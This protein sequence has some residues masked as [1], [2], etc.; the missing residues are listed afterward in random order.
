MPCDRRDFLKQ[1]GTLPAALMAVGY[2]SAAAAPAAEPKLPQIRLGR[3]SI[4]RLICGA[5]PFNAGSHLSVFV[6]H[7]MNAYYTPEQI[8]KTLRR[9]QEVGINCWQSGTGNLGLYRR[10]LDQGG[11]LHFIAIDSGGPESIE[12]LRR[13][14]CI[15]IAHHGETTDQLFKSGRI[16]KIQE[17][18][19]RVRDAG[20][21]VGVSTHM[22]D[23]VDTIESKGWDLDYYMT[24]VY[25]RH[26]SREALEKLLGQAP[27]PVGEVY[28]PNDPPRMFKA[29][30][31]TKRP[32]LAFKILAAGRLSENRGWVE[33]AFRQ[34]LQSIKP[35]DGLIVGIYDQYSDQPAED[36]EF[37]R[38]HG[39]PG[40]NG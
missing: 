36:A 19:K 40:E 26:R 5:N 20:L 7:Q 29:I 9:C 16:D 14:G 18:L 3:Y 30:Q 24:C 17:Y 37:T 6:N 34:T 35:G 32:C 31:Q 22:P 15:A 39:T 23:V 13:G 2:G 1:A 11:K 33:Q 4:S 25:E 21:L 28:L 38:R 12:A 27:I 8:L 10:Y